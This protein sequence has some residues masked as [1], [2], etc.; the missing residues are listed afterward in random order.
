MPK[1]SRKIP[2]GEWLAGKLDRILEMTKIVSEQC[3][4]QFEPD[5]GFWSL[6]KEIALMY[7]V[8]PFLQIASKN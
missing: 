8:W 5:Y 7:W 3:P 6:K 1:R 2:T 4:G